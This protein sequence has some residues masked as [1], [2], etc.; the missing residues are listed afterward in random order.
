MKQK[1]LLVLLYCL[2]VCSFLFGCSSKTDE[3]GKK[4]VKE[5]YTD[6]SDSYMEEEMNLPEGVNTVL[7]TYRTQ[8]NKF[9]LVGTNKEGNK[10]TIW[11]SGDNGATW[12][13]LTSFSDQIE[14]NN[15]DIVS[16]R[17]SMDGQVMIE[18]AD[19]NDSNK[20]HSFYRYHIKDNK[21]E[22]LK[23]LAK[24]VTENKLQSIDNLKE[25]IIIA[26]DFSGQ[27]YLIQLESEDVTALLSGSERMY[28]YEYC[29]DILYILTKDSIKAIDITKLKQ[30]EINEKYNQFL[31]SVINDG[32]EGFVRKR[33]FYLNTEKGKEMVCYA[34]SD[35]I[36][37][38]DLKE[39]KKIIDGSK[40]ILGSELAGLQ[41]M[42]A[43]DNDVYIATIDTDGGSRLF[44]YVKRDEN[45]K[46]EKTLTVYSLYENKSLSQACAIFQQKNPKYKIDFE[47]GISSDAVTVSDAIKALNVKIA[48]GDTPDI[49]VMDG[50]NINNFIHKNLLCDITDVVDK[51]NSEEELF[52]NISHAY[53]VEDKI[54]AVPTK[55]IEMIYASKE[56]RTFAD[57]NE[58]VSYITGL[59][60][61]FPKETVTDA[62]NYGQFISIIYRYSIDDILKESSIDE[63]K[64]EKLYENF[65]KI[66]Q[67]NDMSELAEHE[68]K[69][70][71]NDKLIPFF[72]NGVD[73]VAMGESQ[74]ALDYVDSSIT[75]A[76]NKAAKDDS[77]IIV[78]SL[79]IDGSVYAVPQ[80]VIG[81]SSASSQ[82]KEAERLLKFFLSDTS[83]NAKVLVGCPVNKESYQK[84]LKALEEY[85]G[86]SFT[87]EG[88]DV[89][90]T[91]EVKFIPYKEKEIQEKVE[92][93]EKINKFSNMDSM[94]KQIVMEQAD[95]LFAGNISVKEAAENAK[96]KIELY[97]NE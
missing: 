35:G 23:T 39:S 66:Y 45:H 69:S 97:M 32:E 68:E 33:G 56:E 14:K 12:K 72:S 6:V 58:M 55:F 57:I 74:I 20:E 80:S 13:L 64:L 42:I 46:I 82:K 7:D 95:N 34:S 49:F 89:H 76:I 85:E 10:G 60:K 41:E 15:I 62:W 40:V 61:K 94:L 17:I 77:D 59:A 48:G 9:C 90:S 88:K 21:T 11:E 93:V 38:S 24:I 22:E 31:K 54:Y 29:D 92:E 73:L 70:M 30:V 91:K 65:Q 19:S 96:S 5:E 52:S 18:A 78:D 47:I 53:A 4:Q 71:K 63:E 28:S 27:V 86:S 81:I 43:M 26:E 75:M 84:G 1:F 36:F 2:G 87:L 3:E 44:Q 37:I 83:Q 79:N 50:L 16:A 8:D 67:L 25:D 51:A